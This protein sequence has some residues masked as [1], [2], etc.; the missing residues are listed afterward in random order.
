MSIWSYNGAIKQLLLPNALCAQKNFV[1]L[2]LRIKVRKN[3]FNKK[4]QRQKYYWCNHVYMNLPHN[5]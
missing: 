4:T 3:F 1:Q 2:S 5:Y